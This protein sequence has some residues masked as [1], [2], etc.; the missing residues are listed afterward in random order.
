MNFKSRLLNKLL[1]SEENKRIIA[2]LIKLFATKIVANNFFGRLSRSL[3]IFSD[4]E[5]L[6]VKFF[7]SLF[8]R[9]NNATSAPE[10]SAEQNN[11]TRINEISKIKV[12][13][14]V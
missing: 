6:L 12:W 7:K 11:K 1:F 3:I 13:L 10:T 5:L 9:E 4:L 8:L 2:I 14:V